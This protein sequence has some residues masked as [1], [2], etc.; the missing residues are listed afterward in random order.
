MQFRSILRSKGKLAETQTEV[1]SS[2]EL[3][4][5]ELYGLKSGIRK[6]L[7]GEGESPKQEDR[8]TWKEERGNASEEGGAD[9]TAG[10]EGGKEK[11]VGHDRGEERARGDKRNT[12]RKKNEERSGEESKADADVNKSEEGKEESACREM[13]SAGE[14]VGRVHMPIYMPK[15]T[16]DEVANLLRCADVPVEDPTGVMHSCASVLACACACVFSSVS[17]VCVF[18]C[19]SAPMY[20][21]VNSPVPLHLCQCLFFCLR[22]SE[23][24]FVY[25]S[26]PMPVPVPLC[27]CLC[28]S[29]RFCV[30]LCQCG[31][32]SMPVSL[33]L[34]A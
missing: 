32:I 28:L 11:E 4:S 16:E 17:V 1:L 24:L 21:C 12:L 18:F 23:C 25:F 5:S 9:W 29:V 31:C 14:S 20:F 26:V 10:A 15:S 2:A 33:C 34:F 13:D 22:L 3:V 6:L 27:L 30:S 8:H 19:S 7:H